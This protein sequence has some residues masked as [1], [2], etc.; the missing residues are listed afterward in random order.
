MA[1]L[2]LATDI[3]L[4]MPIA[5]AQ[6]SALLA[7]ALADEAGLGADEAR[8]AYYLAL[9]RTV[10]CTGDEELG[11][12]VLGDDVARWMMHHMGGSPAEVMGAIFSNVGR[13]DSALR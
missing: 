4:G 3:G 12:R 10:G 13:G 6:R 7:R 8:H 11:K 5:H 9:L 1:A 2:S